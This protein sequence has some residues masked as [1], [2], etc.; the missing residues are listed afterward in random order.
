MQREGDAFAV[1]GKLGDRRTGTAGEL[2]IRGWY[3]G[4]VIPAD[5][6]HGDVRDR[7]RDGQR[8][9]EI[10]ATRRDDI[11]QMSK[12]DC[13]QHAQSEHHDQPKA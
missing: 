1:E 11:E 6:D 4:R 12:R 7:G 9:D 2:D 13:R 8:R 3:L 10:A 5:R